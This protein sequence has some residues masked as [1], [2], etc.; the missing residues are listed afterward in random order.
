MKNSFDAYKL[1]AA[2]VLV[3]ALVS[4]GM[5]HM[6][7]LHTH[8]DDHDGDEPGHESAMW[9]DLHDALRHEDKKIFTAAASVM[10]IDR[11]SVAY[12]LAVLEMALLIVL[13]LYS[14]SFFDPHRGFYL[15]RGIAP[16]RRF[17]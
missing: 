2:V 5:L 12:Q 14:G 11:T 15:R 16:Y 6:A 13:F 7:I 10:V 17:T 1:I 4:G 3:C 9:T 8:G